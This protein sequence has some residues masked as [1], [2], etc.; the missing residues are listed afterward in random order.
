MQ[1]FFIRLVIALLTCLLGIGAYI[2]WASYRLRSEVLNSMNNFH[3]ALLRRDVEALNSILAE[4]FVL[5]NFKGKIENRSDLLSTIKATEIESSSL[6]TGDVRVSIVSDKA[7]VT[8]KFKQYY[9]VDE[10]GQDKPVRFIYSFEKRQGR[11]LLV[12]ARP[13]S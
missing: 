10:M 11:W 1:R 3:E 6:M 5:H 9:D 13:G 2:G 8:G 12:S 4:D 7:T